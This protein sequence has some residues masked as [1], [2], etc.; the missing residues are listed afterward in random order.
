VVPEH[1]ADLIETEKQYRELLAKSPD[2]AAAAAE[3]GRV[4]AAR[5]RHAEALL[6]L[7][8]SL[9]RRPSDIETLGEFARTLLVLHRTAE[10]VPWL[11]RAIAAEPRD[12][13]LSF[14]LGSIFFGLG[15]M[16]EARGAFERAIAAAPGM[17]AYYA[18][19]AEIGP[20]APQ[21]RS[22]LEALAQHAG[23]LP[24]PEQAHLHFTQG[25]CLEREGRQ[26]EAFAQYR[27]ANRIM[28]RAFHYDEPQMLSRL[29]TIVKVFSPELMA[30]K[31]GKG[32]CSSVPVF[33]VGMPRSGTTLIEQILAS[34]PKMAGAGEDPAFERIFLGR[35]GQRAFPAAV[36]DLD[37]EA[38][39]YLGEAYV[40][41]IRPAGPEAAR[42]VNKMPPNF[43]YAG[44]IHLALPQARIIHVMRDPVDTCLSC[45]GMR[46]TATYPFMYDLAE[47]GRYYRAYRVLMEHFKR[48]LPPAVF[49]EVSY[50]NLV[51][52]LEAESRRLVAH[53][54]LDWDPACLAFHTNGRPVWSASAAQVRQPLQ[55]KKRWRPD[56][57]ALEPL[58]KAVQPYAVLA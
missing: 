36:P 32:Y 52:D 20:L 10:I 50:E 39:A 1:R 12:H 17:I 48:V 7:E 53:I 46:F 16:D 19:L 37:G 40:E 35:Y 54:G 9:K 41:A 57:L 15:R 30:A 18:G 25:K 49:T 4:L 33:V 27:I 21:H 47:M 24:P 5:N 56:A 28:R 43:L 31:A 51:A 45:Y 38:L 58:L 8:E 13:R 2:D 3:L 55:V 34:H 26:S 42:I 29:Q 44:L 22:A 6:H 11:E 23:S 14:M